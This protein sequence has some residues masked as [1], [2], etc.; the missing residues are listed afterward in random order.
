MA[1]IIELII[2]DDLRGDGTEKN[3]Y[4]RVVQLFSKN[5]NL[6]A[7]ETNEW[8]KGFFYPRNIDD[9]DR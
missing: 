3:P 6:V 9:H 8:N 1:R 4:H 2:T 5:G 7:E